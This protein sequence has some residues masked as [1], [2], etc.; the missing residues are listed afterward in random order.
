MLRNYSGYQISKMVNPSKQTKCIANSQSIFPDTLQ[1]TL[2]VE[3][4]H[5]F[6]G[7]PWIC[8][9][10]TS[11]LTKLF[12]SRAT[13]MAPTLWLCH[14]PFAQMNLQHL[15]FFPQGIVVDTVKYIHIYIYIHQKCRLFFTLSVSP[16]LSIL[17]FPHWGQDWRISRLNCNK[18][19]IH[20]A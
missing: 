6:L 5:H 8:H 15:N 10:L 16:L 11:C 4:K 12:E 1:E 9:P 14:S 19:Q 3:K 17:G 2:Y 13:G 20:S 18:Q 7:N